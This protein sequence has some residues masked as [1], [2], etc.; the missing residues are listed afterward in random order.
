[1]NVDLMNRRN[2]LS[3]AIRAANLGAMDN[4]QVNRLL[5]RADIPWTYV[6]LIRAYHLYSRQVGSPYGMD[7]ML[8]TLERNADVVRSLT[9]YFRI[10][11]DPNIDGLDSDQV[12][13]KRRDLIER[14]ERTLQAQIA[15]I[16]D[17]NSDQ[18]IRTFFNLIQAT[19]RTNFYNRDPYKTPQLVLKFDPSIVDRNQELLDEHLRKPIRSGVSGDKLLN[20]DV[21]VKIRYGES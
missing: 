7:A 15:R 14:S 12:C 3:A 5:I 4:D 9:E 10:K 20:V 18:I 17:L 2:R 19:L 13:D 8:E 6:T 21:G 11:F 16:Q 1:M